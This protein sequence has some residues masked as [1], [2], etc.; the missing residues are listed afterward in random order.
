MKEKH[1]PVILM[2]YKTGTPY[3]DLIKEAQDPPIWSWGGTLRYFHLHITEED[4]DP[5]ITIW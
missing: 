1:D 2:Y 3:L 5:L 4:Q